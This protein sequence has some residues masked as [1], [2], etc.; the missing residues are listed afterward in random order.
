LRARTAAAIAAC[1][2]IVI[3]AI[4]CRAPTQITLVLSTDVDCTQNKMTT[5]IIVGTLA[6]LDARPPAATT[7]ACGAMGT[8][9]LVPSGGDGDEVAVKVVGGIG[10]APDGCTDPKDKRCIIARRVLRYVPHESLTLPISLDDACRGVPCGT[11]ETCARGRCVAVN[12]AENGTCDSANDG[13]AID[14]SADAPGDGAPAPSPELALGQ[15]HSCAIMPDTTVRCWGANDRGQLGLGDDAGTGDVTRPT[16]IPAF[17]TVVSLSAFSE[18]NAGA[19]L[20]DGTVRMWGDNCCGQ[21]GGAFSATSPAVVNGVTAMARISVGRM[22][23][24]ALGRDSQAVMCWG[25]VADPVLTISPPS[26]IAGTGGALRGIASGD[27]LVVFHLSDGTLR[28]I[29]ANYFGSLGSGGLDAGPT[30]TPQIT[31]VTGVA[32]IAVGNSFVI[33]T[34]VDGGSV[35]WGE[36]ASQQLGLAGFDSPNGPTPSPALAGVTDIVAGDQHACGFRAGAL[37]CW[38]SNTSGQLGSSAA[39]RSSDP[40]AVEGL[41]IA[42]TKAWAG[43]YHTCAR[44]TDGSIWCWGANDNGQLGDGTKTSRSQPKPIVW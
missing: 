22:H 21:L 23:A 34:L 33:A 8:L 14:S 9:V 41:P 5:A 44:L 17:A 43:W 13:G 11:D 12:C 29:G 25:K 30:A 32:S 40:I 4:D 19:V 27:T 28:T 24:C 20:A 7:T 36:S 1:A 10:V 18:A 38:G 42:A 16:P 6:S 39:P 15:R 3:G 26:S 35:A 37:V 31:G 2:V